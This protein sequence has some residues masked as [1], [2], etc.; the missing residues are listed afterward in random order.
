M[1]LLLLGFLLLVVVVVVD[2]QQQSMR[3]RYL[4]G[5]EAD[6]GRV[7]QEIRALTT[8]LPTGTRGMCMKQ[9][10]SRMCAC[11]SG[12]AFN[13]ESATFVPGAEMLGA[14]NA[15]SELL[16]FFR[17]MCL[18]DE[19]IHDQAMRVLCAL[20]QRPCDA[21][22]EEIESAAARKLCRADCLA[23]N[24]RL[25]AL[26][27]N[28]KILIEALYRSNEAI[29]IDPTELPVR[30]QQLWS[31]FTD[32]CQNNEFFSDDAAT[33]L[34]MPANTTDIAAPLYGWRRRLCLVRETPAAANCRTDAKFASAT[35]L[36]T[37]GKTHRALMST[38]VI[39]VEVSDS[40]GSMRAKH[41]ASG[42]S[43]GFRVMR[44]ANAETDFNNNDILRTIEM[45][46]TGIKPTLTCGDFGAMGPREINATFALSPTCNATLRYV[47]VDT[48]RRIPIAGYPDVD[49]SIPADAA[50]VSAVVV[51]A[52]FSDAASAGMDSFI[53][54]FALELAPFGN[55]VPTF[56]HPTLY[57]QTDAVIG[58]ERLDLELSK[59]QL[60][61]RMPLVA[62]SDGIA[63][64]FDIGL[65]RFTEFA[66]HYKARACPSIPFE[67][68]MNLFEHS[69][70]I[71]PSLELIVDGYVDEAER[72]R[73]DDE[74]TAR[75]QAPPPPGEADNTTAVAVSI[76][77]VLLLLIGGGGL[78]YW[79]HRS[80]RLKLRTE[81]GGVQ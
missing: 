3:R 21:E 33:C 20:E 43:L 1:T 73:I 78:V 77:V 61:Y 13:N 52:P 5:G 49:F 56:N 50:K 6:I 14:L 41:K 4:S 59:T 10:Y 57:K 67:A 80:G 23:V 37:D 26:T 27:T 66:Q 75:E 17:N 55:I 35:C 72:Q 38:S 2:G 8:R 48:A 54:E 42:E 76:V 22:G 11:S 70:D 30:C 32:S 79:L 29:D 81:R 28:L 47:V 58:E 68:R 44:V 60:H 51:G 64:R 40:V 53:V 15:E 69:V 16:T 45:S 12:V 9:R 63:E 7:V 71:D 65:A 62:V 18:V 34:P 25:E 74:L 46:T 31:N 39:E 36:G 19:S 24:K